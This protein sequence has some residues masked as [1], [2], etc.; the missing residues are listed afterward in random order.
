MK[1][2]KKNIWTNQ[3]D[4]VSKFNN[5]GHYLGHLLFSAKNMMDIQKFDQEI[6]EN[7]YVLVKEK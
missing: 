3:G 2:M 1:L 4:Q 6:V 5:G 7:E